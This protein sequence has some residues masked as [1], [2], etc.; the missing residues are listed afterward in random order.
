MLLPPDVSNVR[1]Q[2][3]RVDIRVLPEWATA[4][5]RAVI[6]LVNVRIDIHQTGNIGGDRYIYMGM[7]TIR[8]RESIS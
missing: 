1:N 8:K 2:I 4:G 3:P 6:L 5:G 7:T